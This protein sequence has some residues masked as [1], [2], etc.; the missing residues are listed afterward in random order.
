MSILK[1]VSKDFLILAKLTDKTYFW[2]GY[3]GLGEYAYS[4]LEKD[5]V[6]EV[7]QL[8]KAGKLKVTDEIITVPVYVEEG[9]FTLAGYKVEHIA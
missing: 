1:K 8:I 9:I 7:N 5:E 6:D 4:K 3:A 2:F